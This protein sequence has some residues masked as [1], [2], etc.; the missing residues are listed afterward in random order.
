M[1]NPALASL[2]LGGPEFGCR[3]NQSGTSKRLE[4]VPSALSFPTRAARRRICGLRYFLI[5]LVRS[6][7]SDCEAAPLPQ[8]LFSPGRAFNRS[9][10]EIESSDDECHFGTSSSVNPIF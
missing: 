1:L 10:H 3:I 6:S 5:M 4:F 9:V 2:F 8:N 7:Q